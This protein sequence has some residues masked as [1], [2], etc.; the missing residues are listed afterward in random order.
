MGDKTPYDKMIE[1]TIHHE[2][3]ALI[4]PIMA[5][6]IQGSKGGKKKQIEKKIEQIQFFYIATCSSRQVT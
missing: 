3:P 5:C 6:M 4:N 2:S 1:K